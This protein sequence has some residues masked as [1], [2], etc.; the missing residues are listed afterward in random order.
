[1]SRGEREARG[2]RWGFQPWNRTAR[3]DA[4]FRQVLEVFEEYEAQRPLTIRQVF[5]RLVAA[6]GF[7][8]TEQA[9]RRLCYY[10]DS[11]RRSREVPF[12]WVRDDGL[13]ALG[14]SYVVAEP[15]AP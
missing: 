1:M 2:A 3:V 12:E 13:R 11:G 7:A 14:N 15:Q 6:H 9:Y 4:V 5:Y 10:L 8:K